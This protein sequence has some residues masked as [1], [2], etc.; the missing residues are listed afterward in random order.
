ML[1]LLLFLNGLHVQ[2]NLILV[3]L[4]PL[5]D[6]FELIY[7]LFQVLEFL[8][9]FFFLL[10]GR[11]L[12]FGSRLCKRRYWRLFCKLEAGGRFRRSYTW[13]FA[14]GNVRSFLCLGRRFIG[15]ASRV[16]GSCLLVRVGTDL[17][18]EVL[19]EKL[20]AKQVKRV[21]TEWIFV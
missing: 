13:Y 19:G 17:V 3:L 9:I 7:L 16:I 18:E 5:D 1:F 15:F 4:L 2:S 14:R 12:H 10:L 6:I 11:F 8:L 20:V 21:L